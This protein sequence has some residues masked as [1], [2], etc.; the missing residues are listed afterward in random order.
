MP[1]QTTAPSNT[2]CWV[3]LQTTDLPAS[4]RFYE[5]LFGWTVSETPGPMPYVMAS[6]GDKR[7]AGMVGIPDEAKTRIPP[8]WLSYVA[9]A[10]ADESAKAV[11]KLGGRIL[12]GPMQ[13]GP[14][15]MAVAQDPTGA[16]FALW[17][18]L[19]SMGTFQYGEI[20]S[21]G[22][23]EVLTDDVETD[24][25]FYAGLFGW[26]LAPGQNPSIPYT[27]FMQGERMVGGMMGI[28][29]EMKDPPPS[30][31]V[32]FSVADAD[33]TLEK[34]TKLGGKVLRP[35][36]D[37]PNIGRFG[38]VAD[39]QGAVFAVITFSMPASA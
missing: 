24:G 10:D 38:I 15:K 18:E 21:L 11:T 36:T 14:G 2:V 27:V 17:Q 9:V 34:V 22:W 19:Q 16:V 33:A 37:I 5:G 39:P 3:E 32:Y 23:S 13:M 8:H 26:S 4:R 29:Q 6:N 31:W 1:E 35:G 7:V 20:A 12:M 30:W 25:K 28:T